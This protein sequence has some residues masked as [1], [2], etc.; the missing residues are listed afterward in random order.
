MCGTFEARSHAEH[1]LI[2]GR[3]DPSAVVSG[4]KLAIQVYLNMARYIDEATD[5]FEASW[6]PHD[7]IFHQRVA[8]MLGGG[9]G[10]LDP[11]RMAHEEQLRAELLEEFATFEFKSLEAMEA[12]ASPGQISDG[13]VYQAYLKQFSALRYRG[14]TP[15]VF[16]RWPWAGAWRR[17]IENRFGGKKPLHDDFDVQLEALRKVCKEQAASGELGIEVKLWGRS[18]IPEGGF[19]GNKGTCPPALTPHKWA[20]T[21][22]P[23]QPWKTADRDVKHQL[24]LEKKRS[25]E[26]FHCKCK[27][28]GGERFSV[29]SRCKIAT[30]CS[31]SCQSEGWAAHKKA[32][33]R[34]GK[35]R[36]KAL[37]GERFNVYGKE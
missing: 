16:R 26:C 13:E 27:P 5:Q 25:A 32:C 8:V 12:A 10:Y 29:C 17:Q 33:K 15:G 1:E 19:Y 11:G 14:L 24:R 31:R 36:E 6:K 18:P 37:A 20:K 30:Y 23:F 2:Y 34:W 21:A 9:H 35:E 3:L 7:T 28:E 4:N 22:A